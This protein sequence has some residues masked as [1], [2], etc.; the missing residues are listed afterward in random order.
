MQVPRLKELRQRAFLT[1]AELAEKS[2]IAETT[3]NRLENERHGA[4]VSTIRKLA[5][6][7]GVSPHELTD[8][9]GK[10]KAAA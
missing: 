3:I 2:G 5:L 8:T 6:S 9:E 10:V 7:L 4:R 1:Q